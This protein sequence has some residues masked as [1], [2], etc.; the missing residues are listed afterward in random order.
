ACLSPLEIADIGE[1]AGD[2]RRRCHGRADQVRTPAGALAAFEVAVG[3]RGAA[4]ALAEAILVHAQAHRAARVA[5][6]ETGIGEYAVQALGFRLAL[7]Q[8]RA[9]HHQ[10]LD[11]VAGD[12]VTL[13][14]VGGQAQVFQARVGAGADEDLVQLDLAACRSVLQEHVIDLQLYAARLDRGY[15]SLRGRQPA[16]HR[17]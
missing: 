4:L 8:A 17:G 16:A 10:C 7:D 2:G 5:P 14:Y 3:G 12:L 15:S 9:R 11:D 13:D 1:V 6:F